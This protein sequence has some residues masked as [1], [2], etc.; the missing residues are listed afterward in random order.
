MA[1][2]L[3]DDAITKETEGGAGAAQP[4]T[5]DQPLSWAERGRL[6]GAG[7][8][9]NFA[10]EIIGLVRGVASGDLTIDEAIDEERKLL[11]IA[12]SKTGSLKYE[13]GG[14]FLPGLLTVPFTGGAGLPATLLRAAAI[15]SG[16][17]AVAAIGEQKGDLVERVTE[18][19]ATVLGAATLGAVAGPLGQKAVKAAGALA[20]PARR[21]SAWLTSKAGGKLPT[22]IEAEVMRVIQEGGMTIDEVVER[23]GQGEIIP[24][25]SEQ[26]A[27]ALRAIYARSG[28]GAQV[29]SETIKRRSETLRRRASE[30]L[31]EDLAPVATTPNVTRAVNETMK[32]LQAAES[33]AYNKLFKESGVITEEVNAAIEEILNINPSLRR[34]ITQHIQLS[35]LPPLFK[36]VKGEAQMLRT[37][38]L[39][40]A[41]VLR[42]VLMDGTK[43]GGAKGNLFRNLERQ[44]RNQIDE[45]SPE[46]KATRANWAKMM[47]AKDAFEDGRKIFGKQIDDAEIYIEDLIAKGDD[48]ALAAFRA[49]VASQ[50]RQKSTTGAKLTLFKNLND[51][52][53]KDRLILEK[54][55]P[56]DALEDA[57]QK[58]K[59]AAQAARTEGRVLGG[60]PTAI[61]L[62]NVKRIGST[63]G[64]ANLAQFTATGNPMALVRLI[65]G[66]LGAASQNLS[67]AQLARAA[68]ILI[69][70]E[71]NVVR[72]ALKQPAAQKL[73]GAAIDKIYQI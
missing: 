7:A 63:S 57:L 19:P 25:M 34:E 22:H 2:K 56:G 53:K 30:T 9:F 61:T 44:L 4:E 40:T 28:K 43:Q 70:E 38:D 49:G 55:Y 21:L 27:N 31:K 39:E 73:L 12:R 72:R 1:F 71:P 24:D 8:A 18:N 29:I 65:T 50:L 47:G 41:E 68:Q 62:E 58:I 60:S 33:A 37:A 10:D 5:V 15:G 3:P 48:E 45:F 23:V 66:Y 54:L 14:A 36:I 17:A 64:I 32:E 20:A 11:E 16:Q 6:T 51:L 46:L 69:S 26:A 59:L 42:R 67:E 35:K 13:L 52:D